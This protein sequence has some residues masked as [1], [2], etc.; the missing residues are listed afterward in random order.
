MHVN[1]QKGSDGVGIL[2]KIWLYKLYYVD[3]ID[4][5]FEGTLGV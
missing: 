3:I 5:L 1:A 4:M 2:V